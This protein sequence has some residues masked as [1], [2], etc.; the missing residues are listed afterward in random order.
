MAKNKYLEG[1]LAI[2]PFS[3][4]T[5]VGFLLDP[6]AFLAKVAPGMNFLLRSRHQREPLVTHE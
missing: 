4:T 3:K 2:W 1:S 6:M 5:S